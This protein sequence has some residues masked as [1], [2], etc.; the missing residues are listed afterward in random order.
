[1]DY[2]QTQLRK[3][4]KEIKRSDLANNPTPKPTSKVKK[5]L[6]NNFASLNQQKGKLQP[7]L[8]PRYSNQD[9]TPLQK[10]FSP[11]DKS[12]NKGKQPVA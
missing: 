6:L 4:L 7:E 5:I 3:I 2:L 11:Q 8:S 10:F 1:M 12:Y 9:G